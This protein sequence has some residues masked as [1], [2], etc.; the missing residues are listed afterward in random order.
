M[1]SR[2]RVPVDFDGH[3][4]NNSSSI[5]SSTINHFI[6]N[7]KFRIQENS[8]VQTSRGFFSNFVI[9]SAHELRR[10]ALGSVKSQVSWTSHGFYLLNTLRLRQNGRHFADD[11]FKCIF[12][13]ENV[14]ILIKISLK[15]VPKDPIINIPAMV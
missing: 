1:P 11:I 9:L 4:A 10:V 14:R 6:V 7:P 3:L 8:R 2:D 15:F 12:L 5:V 13:N